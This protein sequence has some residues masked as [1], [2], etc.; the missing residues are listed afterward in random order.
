MS[1]LA[2]LSALFAMLPGQPAGRPSPERRR[3]KITSPAV[4]FAR[5]H[6]IAY[7]E[8]HTLSLFVV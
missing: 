3:L 6:A 5:R 1:D 8:T 4:T 2:S 7:E